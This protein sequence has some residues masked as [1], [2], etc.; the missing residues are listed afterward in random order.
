MKLYTFDPAPNP[1]RLKMFIDYKGLTLETQQ[2]DMAKAEQLDPWYTAIVPEATLPAL[3][4]DDGSRLTEVIAIVHYLESLYPERPLLGTTPQERAQ[5]LNWNHRIF[6]SL[7]MACA[8]AFRN[9]HPAYSGRALPGPINYEQIP[10]LAERGRA[11]LV[12]SMQSLNETLAQRAFV[13]GDTF[14]FADI[15]LLAVLTFAKWAAKTEPSADHTHILA[16][17]QRASDALHGAS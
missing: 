16:W 15:D 6:N 17:Q 7:F 10:A 11:R 12:D 5:V 9:G 14:T 13:T 8:E 1:A 2:L 4:L 3:V